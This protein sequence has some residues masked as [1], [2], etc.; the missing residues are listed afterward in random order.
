MQRYA[1]VFSV[2][3]LDD[4]LD[5]LLA[6]CAMNSYESAVGQLLVRRLQELIGEKTQAIADG[7]QINP[8]D[9]QATAAAYMAEVNYIRA[10]RDVMQI[11]KDV[12]SDLRK[13][14]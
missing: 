1:V 7:G 10:L 13:A 3:D 12:E 8:S 6:G 2:S 14:G 5:D 11:C 9:P 4:G